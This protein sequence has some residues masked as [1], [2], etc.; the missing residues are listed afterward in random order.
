M[1][2]EIISFNFNLFQ[3]CSAMAKKNNPNINIDNASEF[4]NLYK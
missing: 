3:C 2:F 1:F 4:R